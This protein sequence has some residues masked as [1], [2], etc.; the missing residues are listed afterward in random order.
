MTGIPAPHAP[1]ANDRLHFPVDQSV[2]AD[3]LSQRKHSNNRRWDSSD[4]NPRNTNRPRN[5]PNRNMDSR[6]T[7]HRARLGKSARDDARILGDQNQGGQS[8]RSPN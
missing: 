8:Y 2:P 3:G 7:R 6:N 1:D 4:K 5:P